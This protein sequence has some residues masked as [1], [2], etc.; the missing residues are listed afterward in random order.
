MYSSLHTAT[1]AKKATPIK[2]NPVPTFPAPFTVAVGDAEDEVTEVVLLVLV[3][4]DVADGDDVLPAIAK[5]TEPAVV[6]VDP[7]AVVRVDPVAVVV[8]AVP[9]EDNGEDE[10]EDKAERLATVAAAPVPVHVRT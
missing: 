8:A 3:T 7:A 2:P 1:T 9:N 4:T 10:G 5:V 6:G